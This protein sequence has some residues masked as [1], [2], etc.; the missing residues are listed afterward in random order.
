MRTQSRPAELSRSSEAGAATRA[1]VTALCFLDGFVFASW[2][3]RIPAIKASLALTDAQLGVALL[4]VPVGALAAMPLAGRAAGARGSRAVCT[5]AG[6]AFCVAVTA[7]ALSSDLPTLAA[8]LVALGAANGA[9]DIAVNAQGAALERMRDARVLASL[10]AAFSV[11]GLAGAGAGG[12]AASAGIG[13]AA[14]LELVA[15]ASA[16]V[17]IASIRALVPARIELAG[18]A[19]EQAVRRAGVPARSGVVAL[20][21]LAFCCLVGEGAMADWSGVYLAGPAGASAGLAASGYAFF[22]AAMA[23]SRLA[24]DTLA[25]RLGARRLVRGGATV[26]ATGLA[27]ALVA[28]TRGTA[29][30]G[31]LCMGAG[32]GSVMP[33]VV[34]AAARRSADPSR[35]IASVSTVGYLGFLGGPPMIGLAAQAAG[36]RIALG[37]VVLLAAAM[38]P[39]ARELG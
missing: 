34:S 28:G 20:G 19:G 11:G 5:V 25:T 9:L 10:H 31:L 1:A 27:A 24:G 22:S 13:P 38:I 30:A 32:L 3:S 26:G 4:G 18:A 21:A 33:L 37:L 23:A 16:A 2:V 29:L 12:L 35:A 6:L 17:A 7:P 8:G 39:L 15:L 14:H 36:L